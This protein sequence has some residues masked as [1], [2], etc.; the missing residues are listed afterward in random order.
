MKETA[1]SVA[2]RVENQRCWRGLG[3]SGYTGT[4]PLPST[5]STTIQV[6]HK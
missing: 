1:H 3:D 5:S 6:A 4:P 2:L